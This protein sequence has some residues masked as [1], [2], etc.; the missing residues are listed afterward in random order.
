M[1]D[2]KYLECR[3]FTFVEVLDRVV[4]YKL[5]RAKKLAYR[6]LIHHYH[7]GCIQYSKPDVSDQIG[8]T[9][10][11]LHQAEDRREPPQVPPCKSL[12]T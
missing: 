11:T 7:G 8:F 4:V 5:T 12:E 10:A 3:I 6:P 2:F 1:R 9:S